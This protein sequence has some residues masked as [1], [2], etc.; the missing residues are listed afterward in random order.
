MT[1]I[2][3]QRIEK[4]LELLITH[5][6]MD[7]YANRPTQAR[8]ASLSRA[9]AAYCIK[10]MAGTTD[11]I[12]AKSVTDSFHDRGI[13]AIYYDSVLSRLFLV[14]SK[15][16]NNI[17]W[18]EA[19]EFITGIQKLINPDWPSFKNNPKIYERR[20]EIDLALTDADKIVIV[21][22][23]HGPSPEDAQAISRID[24]AVSEIDGESGIADSVHWCQKDLLDSI[25]A[26]SEPPEISADFYLSNWGEI[27]TPYHAVF[28]RI[29]GQSIA[30]LWKQHKHLTHMNIRDYSNRTD[31]NSAIAETVTKEPEHFWY[32]NNGLTL[33][34]RSIKPKIFGRMNPETA[35]FHFE[36]I[37]LVNG[38]Q[39]TGIIADHIDALPEGE[40]E[41]IWI[42]IRAIAISGCPDQFEKR[43]TKFTNLQNAISVQDFVALDP[44]QSR[45]AT[46]FAIAKRK[47][48]FRWGGNS[49]PI[50][51]QGCTLKEATLGLACAEEDL[52]YA[53]QAKREISVLWDTESPPYKKIFHPE[54]TATRIWNAVLILRAVDEV[55]ADPDNQTY[56][57]AGMVASHLQRVLLHIV[58]QDPDLAGWDSNPSLESSKEDITRLAKNTFSK[59][60]DYVSKHHANEYLAS[61]SKNLIRCRELV[62]GIKSPYSQPRGQGVLFD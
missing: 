14:Q 10:V 11:E 41:K 31:V 30:E 50:G 60:C 24:A 46:D 1:P 12:A 36:G 43:V 16:S 2:G 52:W 56:S 17:G 42:Q 57:R 47:Y 20:N 23:H 15:W 3:I 44:L 26:E 38:A 19:G 29:Q 53:V 4:R 54:V 49:D 37:N 28:G 21:T 27:K 8:S 45:I 32:F 13:D 33:I 59:I 51:N 22:V 9:L 35:L 40:R 5:L 25:K 18:K 58:F 55:L 6:D 34:C 7:D 61:V 48:A 62:D 39:T